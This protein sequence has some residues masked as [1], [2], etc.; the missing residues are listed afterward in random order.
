M[1]PDRSLV[2]GSPGKVMRTL[3]EDE[4]AGLYRIANH[5]VENGERYRAE[6]GS[7]PRG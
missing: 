3:S 1:I 2:L 4:V 7:R 5:Y 6:L